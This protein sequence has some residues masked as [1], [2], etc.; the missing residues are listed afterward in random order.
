MKF[1]KRCIEL[2]NINIIIGKRNP[3]KK[4]KIYKPVLDVL[5]GGTEED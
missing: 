5:M 2:S 1:Y 3:E 4:R